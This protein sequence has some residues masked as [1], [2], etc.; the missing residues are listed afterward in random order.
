MGSRGDRAQGV[1]LARLHRQAARRVEA[2]ALRILVPIKHAAVLD[3]DAELA[4]ATV[5]PDSLEWRVNEWDEFSLEAALQLAEAGDGEVV[6][7]TVGDQPAEEALRAALAKGADRA[8][9]IWDPI[10]EQADPLA[11]AAVLAALAGREDPQLVLTGV[12]SSDAANA[13]TGIALGGL[14]DWPRVAVVRGIEADGEVLTVERE[15]E[16]GAAEIVRVRL[17]ALLTVQTGINEPRYATLR[18]IKQAGQKPLDVLGL[19]DLGLGEAD[20]AELA[21]SRTVSLSVPERGQG[22]TLLEGTPDAIAGRIAE[23]VRERLA[24]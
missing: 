9:R 15:L 21:G 22:A 5:S 20:L 12:Q 13:A 17:P 14:L 19:S 2:L 10:L 24:S 11:I 18:A 7:A 16:G 6:V 8:V 23:I 3:G 1:P 4:G